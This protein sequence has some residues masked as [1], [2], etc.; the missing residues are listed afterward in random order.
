MRKVICSMMVS[1]DGSIKGPNPEL[2]WVII[3]E[4]LHKYIN[5]QQSKIDIHLYGRRMYEVMVN[6]WPT[7][8]T[9]PRNPNE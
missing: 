5:Y 9:N 7:A 3:D 2:D 8:D 1:L 6:Y 4:E